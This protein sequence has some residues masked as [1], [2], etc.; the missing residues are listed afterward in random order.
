MQRIEGPEELQELT[1][2]P[3]PGYGKA[4]WLLFA[5]SALYLLF[6]FLGELR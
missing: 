1:H 4:L 2:E 3:E 5:L 6:S